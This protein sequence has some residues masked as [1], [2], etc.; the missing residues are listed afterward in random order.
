MQLRRGRIRQS[1]PY[2]LFSVSLGSVGAEQCLRPYYVFS[3]APPVLAKGVRNLTWPNR[4]TYLRILLIPAFAVA[5]LQIERWPVFRWVALILL[6][7]IALGDLL[8]GY[9]ARKWNLA[10]IEGKFID[11]IADKL[12]MTTACIFLAFP[13]WG[14][15]GNEAPL[16]ATVVIVIIARDVIISFWV[17]ASLLAGASTSFGPSRMGKLTT[18][19]Q[20]LMVVF[21][22]LGTIYPFILHKIAR[23]L[24]YATAA[25]T[26]IS[27]VQYFYMYARRLTVESHD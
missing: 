5:V 20:V 8:D 27:G 16:S 22:I 14:L 3:G 6:G 15:P 18:F 9:V 7:V 17:L 12:L 2:E 21:M 10:T 11:P 26:I 25:F 13:V 19:L 23:P 1:P 24:S 4:I